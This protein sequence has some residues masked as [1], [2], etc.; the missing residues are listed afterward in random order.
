MDKHGRSAQNVLGFAQDY[1]KKRIMK[2]NLA[3][4]IRWFWLDPTYSLKMY[5]S[6]ALRRIENGR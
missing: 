6:K 2:P 3:R 1:A 5:G 4:I